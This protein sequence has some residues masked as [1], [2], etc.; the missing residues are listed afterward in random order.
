MLLTFKENTE[1]SFNEIHPRGLQSLQFRDKVEADRTVHDV[2]EKRSGK[3][4]IS[5]TPCEERKVDGKFS[6]TY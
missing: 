5:T 4:R 2:H 6:Q 1:E 3:I